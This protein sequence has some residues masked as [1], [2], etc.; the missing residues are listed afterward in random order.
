[1]LSALVARLQEQGFFA[2]SLVALRKMTEI[3]PRERI[4]KHGLLTAFRNIYKDDPRLPVYLAQSKLETDADLKGALQKIDTYF[5][6]E[7]GRFVNHG[8]G[9]GPGKIV[10]VD[11]ETTSI[12]IDFATKKGH[13]LSMEMARGITEFIPE[14]DLR[15]MKLDRL[16]ELKRLAEDDPAEVIRAALRS[17][18]NKA[19]LREIKDRLTDG[20]IPPEAWSRWWTKT[21]L[22]LKTASDVTIGP[23]NNPTLELSQDVRG[24]AQNCLRDLKLLDS[25]EKRLKYF[26]D[27]LEESE[28][29]AEG[30]AAIGAVARYLTDA[31]TSPTTDLTLGSRISLAFLLRETKRR[32]PS[33]EMPA[34][35]EPAATATDPR[36]VLD[37]L[38]SIPIGGHRVE[39]VQLLRTTVGKD[40]TALYRASILRGEPEAADSCMAALVASG[41]REEVDRLVREINER[42][43][44]YPMSYLWY[45]RAVY[46]DRLPEGVARMDLPALLEKLII[47]HSHIEHQLFRRDD[48]EIRKVARSIGT[49]IQAG[50][51]EIIRD[52]FVAATETEG[53]NIANV[54][55]INRSLPR[56]VR[57]KALANM[58]RTRPELAKL[59]G[60]AA[61]AAAAPSGALDS[62]AVYTTDHGLYLLQK[63]YE[64]LVNKLIPENAAEIGRAA[65]H[66]DLSENAEWAAAIERQTHLTRKSEELGAELRRARVIEAS[67]QDGEHVDRRLEGHARPDRHRPARDLHAPRSVGCRSEE[68]RHLVPLADRDRDP[69]QARGRHLQPRAR[70]RSRP[71]P[72]RVARERA[73][74]G[75]RNRGVGVAGAQ[76]VSS[77]RLDRLPGRRRDASRACGPDAPSLSASSTSLQPEAAV[78]RIHV[79]CLGVEVL[80]A[81]LEPLGCFRVFWVLERPEV[82]LVAADASDVFQRACPL[83]GDHD[84]E[85]SGRRNLDHLLEQDHVLPVVT[86]VIDVLDPFLRHL[87]NVGESHPRLVFMLDRRKLSSFALRRSGGV[88]TGMW[89]HPSHPMAIERS[90]ATVRA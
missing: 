85:L 57:D 3:A 78:H 63:E 8:A 83:S 7:V 51:Y 56:D 50:N 58:L 70:L 38:P 42:F 84:R 89:S 22:K 36:A 52:A 14:N 77:R 9:W 15:A 65:S 2:Q 6:F 53:R 49:F 80:A 44:E 69:R 41:K 32:I 59:T 39:I 73:P 23:G 37:A 17:R 48:A 86:E 76:S 46:G 45:A 64:T 29:H 4:L 16:D 27:L 40:A 5:A 30:E 47:L 62:D 68:G 20:V 55:R 67:M 75:G 12:S 82:L 13:R 81:P 26:R 11:P 35:L 60:D 25:T 43:R 71:L 87:E 19:T 28:E 79:E 33:T 31:A 54:L 61:L 88:K 66:G 34:T 21:R 24:Y 90:R 18:R 10:E 1:M 72:R 74:R